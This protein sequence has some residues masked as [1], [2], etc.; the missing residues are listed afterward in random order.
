MNYK[1]LAANIV[2]MV[3]GADNIVHLEH[4]STRLRFA[5]VDKSKVNQ[6]ELKKMPGILGVVIA[7]QVQVIIGN[8]VIEVYDEIMK[9]CPLGAANMGLRGVNKEKNNIPSQFLEFIM[10]IFQPL[11]PALAGAGVLK[12]VLLLLSLL[13]I[14]SPSSAIYTILI[15]IS[16]ATFYFLPIMVAVTTA[17]VLKSNRLVAVAAVG[18]MLLPATTAMLAKGTVIFGITLTNIAYGAQIF[19]A[20]LCVVFLSYMERL[21]NKISPKSIRIF[22]VPMMSLAIT[23]PMTLIILGPLGYNAG[24]IFT[25]VIL[26]I[27]SKLGFIA[28]GILG[29]VLPFM[30]ATGMH[31]TLLP[32]ALASFSQFGFEALYTPASLA[33]NI[34]ESGAC[35]AVALRTKDKTLRQ[36][37]ISAGISA[38][39]GITEPALY[40][41]TL[42]RKRALLGV[43]L[44]G[45]ISGMLVGLLAVKAF[46]PVGPGLA[47]MSQ[48]IDPNNNNNLIMAV[49]CFIVAL[50]GSFVITFIIWKDEKIEIQDT[51]EDK[52][53]IIASPLNGKAVNLSEVKDEIFANKTLGDGIAVFPAD[54]LLVSPVDAEVVM[55]SETKH[56][57]G[58]RTNNGIEILIHIGIDTV[59]MG[60]KGFTSYVKNGDIVKTGDKLISF[61]IGE[62]E[63]AGLDPTVSIVVSNSSKNKVS[64]QF[65]G[66]IKNG[67][68][69]FEVKKEGNE[70]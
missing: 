10:G 11:V 52:V 39:M 25:A 60:G 8:N 57:I 46:V 62:I 7:A 67:D 27:Y 16:D 37:A 17:N 51:A 13:G 32:Y 43:V 66:D 59:T 38:L 70:K 29:A 34:S 1:E 9:I 3:G 55:L 42:Q 23:I 61:D 41:V 50:F 56:A 18:Y 22:F 54:G 14:L 28:L 4:C 15:T 40:G 31:K 65:Y 47:S 19:P 44:S 30:I 35:F 36:V 12:S 6:E 64:N 58:M 24:L 49:I 5:L 21:F 53:S 68:V 33:H 63:K 48:F 26:F 2:K 20:I 69:L 45:G